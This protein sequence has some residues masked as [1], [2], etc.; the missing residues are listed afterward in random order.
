MFESKKTPGKKFGS[1]FAGRRYDEAHTD[2][3]MH[4]MNAE[5]KESPMVEE[6]EKKKGDEKENEE[7][8]HPVVAE[9]GKAHKVI[10]HHDHEAGRHVVTSHHK[11]GHMNTSTHEAAAEAH[12]EG[13]KLAG[14]P[15]DGQPKEK[16]SPYHQ[17][18]DQASASSEEDGFAMPDLA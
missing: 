16:D 17:G 9:H 2:D 18:K 3:G 14:I 4:D 12:E 15:A 8:E 1:M 10:I 11:D 7:D 5:P 6:E 13:R